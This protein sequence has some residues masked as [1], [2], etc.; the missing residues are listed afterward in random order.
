MMRELRAPTLAEVEQAAENI[1][2]KAVRTPLVR[3]QGLAPGVSAEIW[4]KLENL[5]PTGG[6]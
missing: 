6:S 3:F 5:Q 2:G 1:K 4:L